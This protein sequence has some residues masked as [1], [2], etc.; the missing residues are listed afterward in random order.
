MPGGKSQ[1][2]SIAS[3]RDGLLK[4]ALNIRRQLYEKTTNKSTRAWALQV[5]PQLLCYLLRRSYSPPVSRPLLAVAHSSAM[6]FHNPTSTK[7]EKQ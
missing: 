5:V 6:Q 3:A 2:K 7:T 4:T 1:V